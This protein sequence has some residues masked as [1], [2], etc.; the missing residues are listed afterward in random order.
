MFDRIRDMVEKGYGVYEARD[1]LGISE[2]AFRQLP[3]EQRNE[4]QELKIPEE[5]IE[6]EPKEREQSEPDKFIYKSY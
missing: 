5:E 4:L 1:L 6:E 3:I 2:Y